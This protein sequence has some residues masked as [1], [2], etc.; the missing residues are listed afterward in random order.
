MRV[1][2][3]CTK[4]S[5]TSE[6]FI[7]DLVLGLERAGAENHVL[8][9]ARLNVLERPFARV[10]IL[11]ISW[12]QKAAFAIRKQ[13]LGVYK[14]PLP[15]QA[16]RQALR[17][18]RPDV[19][20]A[21]FGGAGAAIA[22]AA[23]ELE[24]PLI[25]VFHAFDLFMRHF[26]PETYTA[27]WESD[28][29]AVAVSKHGMRRLLE[30][31]CPAE[32]VRVIH[33]GVD[34]SRFA[35]TEDLQPGIAGFQLVTLGRFVEKKGFDDLIR[36]VAMI[37]PH[38]T[39]RVCLDLWGDGPL[40]QDLKGLACRLGLQNVVTF[41]GV[42]ASQAVPRLLHQ[43]DA[44]VLPSK[45]ARNGDTEGI[46]ITIMEA[47]AAG[48]PV[49]TTL[50]AGI[51]EA[52]PAANHELLAR[53]GDVENLAQK[54]LSLASQRE[55]WREI[56]LRGKEWVIRRFSLNDE[57]ASYQRLFAGITASP[58]ARAL[59]R[60]GSPRPEIAGNR[61]DPESRTDGTRP[62]PVGGT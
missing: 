20:L 45:T 25:V 43:Y 29:Q 17:E 36:A 61:A 2:H 44:F 59:R 35:A 22:P 62:S 41:R 13:W 54:L 11:P 12:W 8:T 33:C 30:L 55:R 1:A 21:H 3:I 60:A 16:T 50:H 39:G 4:F 7:Y 6:T 32:R 26:R 38:V 37:R 19:I 28:T 48:M 42:A 31:G 24:I 56:G 52:I 14:F 10:R 51:P 47:Q 27:L 9:A 46:P 40:K 49:V 57:I 5:R 15:P 23:H 18:I 58:V 53:E 34:A